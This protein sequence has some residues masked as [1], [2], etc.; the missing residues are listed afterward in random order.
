MGNALLYQRLMLSPWSQADKMSFVKEEKRRKLDASRLNL[1]RR[2]GSTCRD[3]FTPSEYRGSARWNA[4]NNIIT[5]EL[6]RFFAGTALKVPLRLVRARRRV[7]AK[8][9]NTRGPQLR[10]RLFPQDKV[11]RPPVEQRHERNGDEQC[12]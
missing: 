9:V 5:L 2:N 10:L 3:I 4:A 7:S 8:R 6:E 11:A 12:G 1:G